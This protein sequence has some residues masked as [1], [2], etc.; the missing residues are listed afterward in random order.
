MLTNLSLLAESGLMHPNLKQLSHSSIQ[1]LHACPKKLQIY[2]LGE[3]KKKFFGEDVH[4]DF[5]SIVGIGI[6]ELFETRSL[7]KAYMKM[8]LAWKGM[9]DDE[10]GEKQKKT[11]WHCLN[12][13]DRFLGLL[14]SE[15][16]NCVLAEFEGK[17]AVELGFIIDFGNG[18]TYR[19][20]LDALLVDTFRRTLIPYEG[21]TTGMTVVDESMYRHSGQ[22]LGYSLVTDTICHKMG[23]SLDSDYNIKYALYQSKQMEWTTY[24]FRKM[25]S[26]RAVWIKNILMDI[27]Q[28][29]MYA[30]EDFWPMHGESCFAY[31]RQCSNY[32]TC[33]LPVEMLVGSEPEVKVDDESRYQFRFT[34]DEIIAAQVANLP[35]STLTS[36]E[37]YPE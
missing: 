20:F 32:D 17:P 7:D 1:T 11:F 14:N 8:F 21:K 9:I 37:D 19:G 13:A 28:M 2:K 18:W 23:L 24:D 16:S 34:I 3:A 4:Q 10:A 5:G 25:H 6:Q 12:S 35:S 36:L 29:E 15:F 31:G 33:E 26:H 22:N 27:Q 30:K